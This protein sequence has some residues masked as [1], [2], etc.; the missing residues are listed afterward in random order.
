MYPKE[1]IIQQYIL[2]DEKYKL[3]FVATKQTMK[4]RSFVFPE[5]EIEF[6]A[7]FA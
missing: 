1:D 3:H 6:A 2:E 5:I 7:I 4:I